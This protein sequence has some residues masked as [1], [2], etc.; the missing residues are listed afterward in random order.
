MSWITLTEDSFLEQI[1]G[2]EANA[3]K[4]AALASGQGEPLTNTLLKIV[5]TVRGYVAANAQ[6]KLGEGST[7]PQ[8]LESAAVSIARYTA[9]N[10]LPVKSL[11]TET[12][13]SEYKDALTLLRDVAAG[14]FAIEQPTTESEQ[15]ISGPAVEI[16]SSTTRQATRAKLA[17]L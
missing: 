17:G 4:T 2:A 3:I 12:R 14:R 15:V 9:L 11:L 8:E 6:N 16:V 1:T 7:I 5:Q 13:I 10:R